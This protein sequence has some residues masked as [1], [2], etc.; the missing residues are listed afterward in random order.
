[1]HHKRQSCLINLIKKEVK[2][3]ERISTPM[4]VL[5]VLYFPLYYHKLMERMNLI[6]YGV[7]KY[8][9]EVSTNAAYG[10]PLL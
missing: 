2:P 3:R 4:A 9:N 5:R 1:M 8:I 7:N 6:H 10:Y